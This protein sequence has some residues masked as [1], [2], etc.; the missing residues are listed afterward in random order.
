MKSSEA[1]LLHVCKAVNHITDS[2][3]LH[4]VITNS[5]IPVSIRVNPNKIQQTLPYEKVQWCSHGYYLPKRPIF[6]LDPLFHAG[7][8]YVQEAASMFLEQIVAPYTYKPVKVFDVCAAP[9]GKST[10]VI[11]LLQRGSLLVANEVI[12]SRAHILSENIIKW[13]KSNCVVTNND[14]KDF[15]FL[16]G[17][18]DIVIVDAPCSG[19]GMFRK[20]VSTI[21]EWSPSHVDLCSKRQTRILHDVWN[22]LAPGG[23]L[24]YST[25]TF[26]EIENE[27]VVSD[28]IAQTG[29]TCKQISFFQ[30]WNITEHEK[31]GAVCYRFFPH[32]TKGEG[33]TISVICKHNGTEFEPPK[34]TPQAKN[35]T[36]IP[37]K[38][39]LHFSNLIQNYQSIVYERQKGIIWSFAKDYRKFLL[40]IYMHCNVIHAGIPLVHIQGHKLNPLPGLAFAN[41]FNSSILPKLEVD[42]Y[43]ALRYFKKESLEISHMSKGWIQLTYKG[44]SIGFVKNIGN[45]ANNPYP[46]EWSIK[47]NVHQNQMWS[48]L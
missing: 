20:D 27:D 9:G 2:E 8:Y 5:E 33:F 45:R 6:T 4:S 21:Q 34:R 10:H 11:S 36:I 23:I 32:K 26:N 37:E 38:N 28:F 3:A 12:R 40:D 41:S 47:M 18:F 14:P 19:E 15:D 44:V 1:T 25:C 39:R 17:F 7:A 24:I 31:K 42:L 35:I 30:D 46:Q 13:G 29:A 43:T 48:I 16:S 22:T